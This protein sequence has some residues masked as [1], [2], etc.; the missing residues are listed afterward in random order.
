MNGEASVVIEPTSI[1]T[2]RDGPSRSQILIATCI[3][4]GCLTV[5]LKVGE[6]MKASQTHRELLSKNLE[7]YRE[8]ETLTQQRDML[9]LD[10]KAT[11]QRL[12]DLRARRKK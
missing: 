5:F 10:V 4:A 7:L 6:V 8:L 9:N 11:Q 1:P 12:D 3:V 2:E